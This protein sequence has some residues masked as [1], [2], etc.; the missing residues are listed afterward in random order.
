MIYSQVRNVGAGGL[1][2]GSAVAERHE[3]ILAMTL[4][5]I[6]AFSQMN[7]STGCLC[8]CTCVCV[9]AQSSPIIDGPNK[10]RPEVRQ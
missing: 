1:T 10:R 3:M 4:S 8:A 9:L 7:C 2:E 6:E 5:D